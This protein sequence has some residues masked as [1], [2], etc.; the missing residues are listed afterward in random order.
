MKKK[1]SI[2]LRGKTKTVILKTREPFA[3]KEK[4]VESKKVYSRKNQS[5]DVV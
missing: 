1:V 4:V 2:T 3:P 5:V